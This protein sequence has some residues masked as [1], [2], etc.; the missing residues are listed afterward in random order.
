MTKKLDED[1]GI[2]LKY[3]REMAKKCG[4]HRHN[5]LELEADDIF[6]TNYGG[7]LYGAAP[8]AGDTALN[9]MLFAVPAQPKKLNNYKNLW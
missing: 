1:T 4:K 5:L 7:G 9:T 6:F 2:L 3:M 8:R